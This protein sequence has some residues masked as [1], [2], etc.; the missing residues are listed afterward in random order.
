MADPFEIKVAGPTAANYG[1][2]N[3]TPVLVMLKVM[4]GQPI[5]DLV[6][7]PPPSGETA[8]EAATRL[9]AND[10]SVAAFNKDGFSVALTATN[11]TVVDQAIADYAMKT[12][13]MHQLL[14]TITPA[15]VGTPAMPDI[16]KVVISIKG[17]IMSTDPT[18]AAADA[19]SKA[20][21]VRHTITLSMAPTSDQLAN[22]P[23]VVSVQRLR[24]GSQTVVAAFQEEI[25]TDASFDVRFVIT[26]AHSE[27]D[28]GKTADENAKRLIEVENG[29]PS[30][31]VV[32]VPFAR[33]AQGDAGAA[34]A[35]GTAA[36]AD[37]TLVPHPIEGMYAHA[38]DGALTGVPTGADTM[39]VPMPTGDD[40]M[41]RQYRVTITPH[42]KKGDSAKTF[43]VKIK[44]KDFHDGGSPIRNTYL[45]PGFGES[46]NLPNGREILTVK[47]AYTAVDVKAGYRVAIPKEIFIPGGGYL[48]VAMDKA[49][50]E[51]DTTG[52]DADRTKDAPRAT[53]RTPAQLLYTTFTKLLCRT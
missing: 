27:Y 18:L 38:G 32:G 1:A 12:P 5:A 4:S 44:V 49:G 11:V 21:A 23:K 50:S 8:A 24:P 36:A 47:V 42:A 19:V 31:L 41:Y 6:Y 25:V 43:D 33:H 22:I 51:V 14:V 34:L 39:N 45:S 40:N 10:I 46:A 37:D 29:V 53:F 2:T 26:E 9:A 28:G 15:E 35:P 20:D 3:T 48:I 30:N 7:T 52:Q 16:A 17:G 13:K